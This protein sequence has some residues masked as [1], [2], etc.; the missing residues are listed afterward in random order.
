LVSQ[1]LQD[2]AQEFR[3]GVVGHVMFSCWMCL[4]HPNRKPTWPDLDQFFAR[5]AQSN[6]PERNVRKKERRSMSCC[7]RAGPRGAA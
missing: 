1:E 2:V 6:E 7:C 4:R 5:G 3:I